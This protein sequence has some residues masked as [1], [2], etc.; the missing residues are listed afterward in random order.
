[1]EDWVINTIVRLG[2]NPIRAE[3]DIFIDGGLDSLDFT[4]LLTILESEKRMLIDVNAII[5]D[6]TSLRTPTGLAKSFVGLA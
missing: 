4:E 5:T 2:G 1:M 3:E 6:W